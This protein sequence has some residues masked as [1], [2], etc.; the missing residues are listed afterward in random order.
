MNILVTGG[1]GFIGRHLCKH[2]L[3]RG[4]NIFC[5]D[6]LITSSLDNIKE[7]KVYNNFH[8]EN[9]SLPYDPRLI[10]P[11]IKID[12]IY[13][14]ASPTDPTSVIKNGIIT[15]SVNID[16]TFMLL[17]YYPNIPFLFTSSVQIKN[18]DKTSKIKD[19]IIGKRIAECICKFKQRTKI[20][21]MANIYGPYM[22]INDS[23]VIPTFIRKILLNQDINLWNGGEQI[24]SFCYVDDIVDGLIKFMNSNIYGIVEFGSLSPIKIKDL[25][26][27]ILQ[28]IKSS[29]KVIIENPGCIFDSSFK[30]ADITKA[31]NLLNWTPNIMLSDGLDIMIE[32]FKERIVE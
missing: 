3:N 20:A 22:G 8:F 14:L 28:K 30:I 10:F 18:D 27:V 2:L 15:K 21:R 26:D 12:Q 17:E 13:H 23:R 25:A 16:A 11:Q 32:D 24:D 4:E 5:I 19:Y 1:A 9:I 7:F 6:S 29:S 31:L